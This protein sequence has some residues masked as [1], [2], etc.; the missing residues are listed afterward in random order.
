MTFRSYASLNARGHPAQPS[1]E[2][3]AIDFHN[4]SYRVELQDVGSASGLER[5]VVPGALY[6]KPTNGTRSGPE[7]AGL[8]LR[9]RALRRVGAW[10]LVGR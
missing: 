8:G 4:D 7:R 9:R 6:D 1:T 3:G 5:I 2:T 10:G